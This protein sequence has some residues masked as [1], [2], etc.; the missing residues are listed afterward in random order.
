MSFQLPI[1]KK[2]LAEVIGACVLLLD[3]GASSKSWGERVFNSGW[4]KISPWHILNF[5]SICFIYHPEGFLIYLFCCKLSIKHRRN[6]IK[7]I[8]DS[9]YPQKIYFSN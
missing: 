7:E 1:K 3:G 8:E 9:H 6:Y 4:G 2:I 5:K